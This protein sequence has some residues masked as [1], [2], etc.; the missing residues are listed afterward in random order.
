MRLG[1]K[2]DWVGRNGKQKF[3]TSVSHYLTNV[4][5]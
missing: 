4:D 2:Q 3:L 5:R 1:V